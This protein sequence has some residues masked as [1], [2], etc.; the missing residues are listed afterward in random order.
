[1]WLSYDAEGRYELWRNEPVKDEDE[2]GF[3]VGKQV[4]DWIDVLDIDIVEFADFPDM[5]QMTSVDLKSITF[6]VR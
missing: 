6:E 1:M 4:D 3:V 5:K 2:T